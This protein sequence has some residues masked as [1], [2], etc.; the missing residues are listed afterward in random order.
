MLNLCTSVFH[1]SSLKN[2]DGMELA[3]LLNQL[4]YRFSADSKQLARVTGI[5]QERVLMLL[6]TFIQR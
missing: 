1:K 6:D 2:L 5:E 3:Q 4:R